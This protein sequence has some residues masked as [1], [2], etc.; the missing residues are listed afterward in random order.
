ML[1]ATSLKTLKSI[2]KQSIQPKEVKIDPSKPYLVVLFNHNINK[3]LFHYLP[4]HGDNITKEISLKKK[5]KIQADTI[6]RSLPYLIRRRAV[7][8]N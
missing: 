2:F 5:L 6:R 1:W 8:N 7:P 4:S 3:Y